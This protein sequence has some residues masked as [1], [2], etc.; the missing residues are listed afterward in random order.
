MPEGLRQPVLDRAR[1][2]SVGGVL[3]TNHMAINYTML[4]REDCGPPRGTFPY[5]SWGWLSAH[6]G[7]SEPFVIFLNRASDGSWVF[8]RI[9]AVAHAG[10]VYEIETVGYTLNANG[11]PD[12]WV[13]YSKHGNVVEFDRCGGEWVCR[14]RR[15][16][17]VRGSRRRHVLAVIQCR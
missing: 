5:P 15:D 11:K 9:V 14:E 3:D 6:A 2:L 17:L 1:Y 4:Y 13:G 7:D 10:T 8:D 12:L 16:Q